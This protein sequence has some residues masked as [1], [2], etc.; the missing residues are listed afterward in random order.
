MDDLKVSL[1]SIPVEGAGTKLNRKRSGNVKKYSK[2]LSTS[3]I[4]LF[5]SLF[6]AQ[7]A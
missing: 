3:H 2:N 1:F 6:F 4:C 7:I 5:P